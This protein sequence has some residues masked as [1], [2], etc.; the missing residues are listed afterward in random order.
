MTNSPYYLSHVW[1]RVFVVRM[2]YSQE[3][4]RLKGRLK[5][6]MLPLERNFDEI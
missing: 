3:F 1:P 2:S 6:K 5:E 4:A